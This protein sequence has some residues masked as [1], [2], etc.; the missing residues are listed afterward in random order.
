MLV[1]FYAKV[2]GSARITSDLT[3]Y[4]QTE[5][6]SLHIYSCATVPDLHRSSLTYPRY[7]FCFSSIVWNYE[8][9]VKLR[10]NA[11]LTEEPGLSSVCIS[12]DACC[13]AV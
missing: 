11:A 1:A 4:R 12:L 2:P 10:M 8:S 5:K 3:L 9:K 6:V 7:V 13:V